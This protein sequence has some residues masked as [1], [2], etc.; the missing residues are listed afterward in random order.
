MAP[1]TCTAAPSSRSPT[2]SSSFPGSTEQPLGVPRRGAARRLN[3][4]PQMLPLDRAASHVDAK[5]DDV[6]AKRRVRGNRAVVVAQ[7][8]ER[9]GSNLVPLSMP[10]RQRGT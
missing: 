1:R 10:D 9:E 7:P 4:S 3:G 5:P 8:G 2:A 6:E